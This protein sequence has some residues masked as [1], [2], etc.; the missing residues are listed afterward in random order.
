MIRHAGRFHF[1][2]G[3]VPA[4]A[5]DTKSI[6]VWTGQHLTKSTPVR[7]IYVLPV[8]AVLDSMFQVSYY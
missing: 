5:I 4:D 8:Q 2:D 6:W 3:A 1:V 7:L